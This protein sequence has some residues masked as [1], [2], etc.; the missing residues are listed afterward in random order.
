VWLN[1]GSG[2]FQDVAQFV[3]VSD[4]YDGRAVALAD[5]RNRGSLD[6]LVANQRGPVCLYR[7]E[8]APENHWVDLELEGTRSNRSAIGAQVRLFWNGQQQL[9]ELVSASGYSAQN[10]RRLHFGLGATSQIDRI[11]IRWP[12]GQTQTITDL[13]ADQIHQI[14]EP[15]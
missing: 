15:K 13:Q 4:R 9:Q 6:V 3:G 10:Q 11:E 12:S 14:R 7:S 2:K 1:D 5:T 8:V